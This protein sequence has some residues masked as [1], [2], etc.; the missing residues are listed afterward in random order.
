[1]VQQTILAKYN[2]AVPKTIAQLQSDMAAVKAGGK[3]A[4]LQIAGTTGVEGEWISKPF[5]SSFGVKTYKD[6]G[7]P[8]TKTMFTT[9]DDWVSKGYIAK[10]NVG[11][12]QTDGVSEFLKGDTAF[13][14]GGN[15]Q[16]AQA[17]KTSVKVGVTA[18]PAGPNGPGTVY[19][20]GQAEAM[21][22]FSKNQVLAWKFLETT[23]LPKSFELQ[24][25]AAGSIPARTDG[26][27]ANVEPTI[28]A[29]AAELMAGVALS[30]DTA[31]TLAVGNLWSGVLA[32][33][34][35]PAQAEVIGAQIAKAAK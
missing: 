19:L 33:Q 27:P 20:G 3:Y 12:S 28:K 17:A 26:L 29:Y 22:A 2:L 15:W 9:L 32:G 13:Y 6:Y 21:G 30:P 31:S 4:G 14:V 23:W 7:S 24:R 10:A 25:L 8:A 34:T 16:L 1:L 5:F 11:M 18:M 35:S